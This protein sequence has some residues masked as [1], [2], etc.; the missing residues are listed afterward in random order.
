MVCND[1]MLS[2][3]ILLVEWMF[4]DAYG[5]LIMGC[6]W[7]LSCTNGL[8]LR[9]LVVDNNGFNHTAI[10]YS[11]DQYHPAIGCCWP[12]LSEELLILKY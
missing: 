1:W 9:T 6:L 3:K 2:W 12:T 5:R 10:K 7:M 8:D 4:M 11:S